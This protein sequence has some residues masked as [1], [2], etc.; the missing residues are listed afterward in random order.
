[1][2]KFDWGTFMESLA[3]TGLVGFKEG[4]DARYQSSVIDLHRQE[5]EDKAKTAAYAQGQKDYI[6]ERPWTPPAATDTPG[7]GGSTAAAQIRGLGPSSLNAAEGSFGITPTVPQSPYGPTGAVGV[8]T[9]VPTPMDAGPI[10]PTGPVVPPQGDVGFNPG[11]PQQPSTLAEVRRQA[12]QAQDPREKARLLGQVAQLE[13]RDRKEL[14]GDLHDLET[15]LSDIRKFKVEH[16]ATTRY[17]QT[18]KAQKAELIALKNDPNSP[19][20]PQQLQSLQQGI[21]TTDA[22]I[23]ELEKALM[24]TPIAVDAKSIDID[25]HAK[26]LQNRGVDPQLINEYRR[27]YEAGDSSVGYYGRLMIQQATGGGRTNKNTQPSRVPSSPPRP[28]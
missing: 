9:P 26:A 7:I 1:M 22:Q 10:T 28:R 2:S 21:D 4:A 23:A 25:R 20:T 3:K 5:I 19:S 11:G 16:G 14:E 6:P 18:L 17:L 8:P 13:E 12:N 27:A 15:G 24:K